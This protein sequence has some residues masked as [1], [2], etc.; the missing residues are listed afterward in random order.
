VFLFFGNPADL[1]MRS[2]RHAS[3]KIIV[4]TLLWF[5]EASNTVVVGRG[6]GGGGGGGG[7]IIDY[8]DKDVSVMVTGFSTWFLF[9]VGRGWM[10]LFIAVLQ[11][12]LWPT[13]LFLNVMVVFLWQVGD[14]APATCDHLSALDARCIPT[15]TLEP[16][17]ILK[18]NLVQMS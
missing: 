15:V 9:M 1:E 14:R 4:A 5:S 10:L 16:V 6:G 17:D 3:S 12:A 13:I 8:C 2:F 11:S 18:L 7:V